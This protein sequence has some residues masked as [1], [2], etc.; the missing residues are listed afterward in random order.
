MDE[1]DAREKRSNL[2]KMRALMFYEEEKKRRIKKIKSKTFR[3]LRKKRLNRMEEEKEK[4][5]LE[6]GDVEAIKELIE[7]QNLGKE[8]KG[9][10][11]NSLI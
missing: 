4:N 11:I 7:K 9:K 2:L 6:S 5:I 1:E 10:E 3:K 8:K